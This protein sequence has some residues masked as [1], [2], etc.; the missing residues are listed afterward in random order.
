VT[1]DTVDRVRAGD[2][3]RM[4]AEQV[5]GKGGGRADFAQAGGSEPEQL[6]AA[7]ES[8]AAWVEA[9]LG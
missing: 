2:V 6:D 8:V 3:I 1:K 4:V 5:G 9:Q 7:L